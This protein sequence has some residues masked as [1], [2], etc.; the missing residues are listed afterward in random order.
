MIAATMV[1]A[2]ACAAL[3]GAEYRPLATLRVTAKL[4]ASLA[5]LAV[6]LLAMDG[7]PY[8]RWIVGGLALGVIGDVALLGHGKRPFV[9]GLGAFQLGHRAYIVAIADLVPPRAWPGDAGVLA[10]APIVVGVGALALLWPRLGNLR[11]PVIAY[12]LAIVTMM[13][14][15]LA[16]RTNTRLVVGAALFFASDLAVARERF[17]GRTFA[18]KAWGLPAYYAAQLLIA[19]SIRG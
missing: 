13:I 16:A 17:V 14:G 8:A 9:V 18:N 7:G 15:A 19:W 6:G 2:V 1:C 11:V 12:V 3:V 4:V 10:A 5:F